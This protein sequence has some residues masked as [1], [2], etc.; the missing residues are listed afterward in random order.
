[1]FYCLEMS[2][3]I[4]DKDNHFSKDFI[5]FLK[6]SMK[7]INSWKHQKLNQVFCTTDISPIEIEKVSNI[8]YIK[9][10]IIIIMTNKYFIFFFQVEKV[11]AFLFVRFDEQYI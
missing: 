10:I 8:Y 2:A 7:G 9:C 5:K 4:F 1:M 6:R 11:V 3:G